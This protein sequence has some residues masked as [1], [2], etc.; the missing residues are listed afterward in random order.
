M[1]L[2]TRPGR[3]LA[4]IWVLTLELLITFNTG[5]VQNENYWFLLKLTVWL[6]PV[7][8]PNCKGWGLG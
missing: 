8:R 7:A 1:G 2:V 4:V 5:S 6:E 3:L